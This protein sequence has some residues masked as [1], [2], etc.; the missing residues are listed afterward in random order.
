MPNRTFAL[1]PD[2][3]K[4]LSI[5][6]TGMWKNITVTLDDQLVGEIENQRALKAGQRFELPDG[7][8]VSV[9][10]KTGLSTELEV[11][12]NGVPVPGSDT[13]PQERVNVATG[14]LGFIA[15]LSTVVGL[16]AELGQVG[17]LLEVGVGLASVISGLLFAV[18]TYLVGWRN[19]QV[20]LIIAI[21]LFALDGIANLVL[22]VAS[23][24][25]GIGAGLVV[26]VFLLLPMIR[27]VPAMSQLRKLQ[28]A[29]A[30]SGD[31]QNP[32]APPS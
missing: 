31:P 26:R 9:K 2:G 28:A 7:S 6:W 1:E 8:A 12:R 15:G 11:T 5:A 3:P 32:Y 22:S 19:S 14:V 21:A 25:A 29:A 23:G 18:F 30:G 17:F 4:R 27:A 13:H 20:A 16:V 24:G 10:L